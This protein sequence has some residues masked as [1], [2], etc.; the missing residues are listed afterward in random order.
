MDLKKIYSKRSEWCH[1]GDY[2]YLL[3]IA[4]SK[5]YTGSPIFNALAA[6]RAGADLVCCLG[7]QRAMDVAASFLPDLIT[8]PLP[9]DILRKKH[10]HFVLR[11]LEKFDALV[12]GS[13]LGRSPDTF[14]AIKEIVKNSS[15]PMVIDA[16]GIRALSEAK[17]ILKGK[18]VVLT[19]HLEEFEIF[20][21]EKI[22]DSFEKR[23]EK[24]KQW[25]KKLEIVILLKGHFD[26][27][28]D[29]EK[30]EIN[31]TG[32]PYM[33][34]GGFGDTLAGILGALLAR[35]IDLFEAAKAAAF[36]NGKAGELAS[37]VYGEGVLAS[38]I[39]E[40]IPKVIEKFK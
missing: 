18:K 23:A 40:F 25:A 30:I 38:D 31:K 15:L 39:F 17:E 24:V 33:T 1:K 28:S 2:G 19:P 36:I 37:E 32:S 34:K 26:I 12:L 16:D 10:L 8:F 21:G 11:V 29:G 13:G 27:I 35:K 5:K 6:L 3:V 14:S 4:G 9:G 22:E 20:I 7:P